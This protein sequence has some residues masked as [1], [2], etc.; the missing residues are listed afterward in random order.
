MQDKRHT[1]LSVR[2]EQSSLHNLPAQLT[3]LIGREQEVIAIRN[4]LRNPE[5]RL[6]TL[7]GTPGV[8]KTHLALQVARELVEDFADGVWF[9]PLAPV[10][11]PDLLVSSIAKIFDNGAS[12]SLPLLDFLQAYLQHKHLLLVL[13][14]FE[15]LVTDAPLLT[16]ILEA[17]PPVKMLVTSREV[18]HLRAER[19]FLVPPLA[20]PDLKQLPDIE[21]L[22]N[23]AAVALFLERGQAVKADFQLTPSNAAAIAGICVHLDGIPLAIELAAVRIKFLS[24]QSLLARLDHRL[25]VLTNGAR[26]LPERQ[27][28]L[29]NMIQWSYELLNAE[30]QRLFQRPRLPRRRQ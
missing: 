21:T 29:L 2:S 10:R 6:L 23:Y 20:L 7:T 28:T 26:D 5:V 12:G 11:E 13:D 22:S 8:G 18:L 17:C 25:Q 9:V 16:T 3:A 15:Q 4:L 14:N 1:L 19:Q 27:Q 30:E 24:P